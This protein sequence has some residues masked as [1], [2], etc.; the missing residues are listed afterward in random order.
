MSKKTTQSLFIVIGRDYANDFTIGSGVSKK[1]AYLDFE[2]GDGVHPLQIIEVTN[3]PKSD[4]TVEKLP[5][6]KVAATIK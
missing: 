6:V 3:L 5:L 4:S 2:D 1:D